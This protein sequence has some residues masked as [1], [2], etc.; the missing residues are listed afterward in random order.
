MVLSVFEFVV[1]ASLFSIGSYLILRPHWTKIF[2]SYSHKD[3][4]IAEHIVERLNRY[5]FRIYVDFGLEIHANNLER[6]LK[7]AI[8]KRDIFML[9]ASANSA[10]SYWVQFE[11]NRAKQKDERHFSQWRDMVV[12]ALDD[13][14]INIAEQLMSFSERR[15][16]DFWK[17][18]RVD[19]ILARKSTSER[20]QSE[21]NSKKARWFLGLW[22][23]I[24]RILTPEVQTFDLRNDFEGPMREVEEYLKNNTRFSA[25]WPGRK[26]VL[27]QKGI[28][29]YLMLFLFFVT[30]VF[31][32]LSWFLVTR[33][34]F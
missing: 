7:N 5:K 8:K 18:E 12:V 23:F 33:L 29:L 28:I 3:A 2:F 11:I 19:A 27:L 6:E 26:Y 9:T 30:V 34:L 10:D 17:L 32:V 14:G 15:I 13:R 22:P 31:G 25:P 21:A 20:I 4:V 16:R 24:R 1:L